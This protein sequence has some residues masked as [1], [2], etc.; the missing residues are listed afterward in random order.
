MVF[1]IRW[2]MLL[3]S[4]A[5]VT[6]IAQFVHGL[7]S[8]FAM[9][10]YIDP[11]YYPLWSK[12][13]MPAPGPPPPSFLVISLLFNLTGAFLFAL[14][15]TVLQRGLPGRSTVVKGIWYGL[16]VFLVASVPSSLMLVLLINLPLGIVL[17]W[18]LEA[19]VID[20]AGGVLVAVFNR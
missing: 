1:H 8:I 20:L 11:T 2:N 3:V 18:G 9:R 6:I 4:V 16:L 14:V 15:Y 13:M 10:Y 12:I 5:L 17:L 7:D 19:L